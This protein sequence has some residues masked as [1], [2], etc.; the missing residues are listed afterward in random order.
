MKIYVIDNFD[1]ISPLL[2]A[3][4]ADVA[5]FSD[6]IQ[7]F[8]A[9]EQQQPA[10]IFL[11]YALREQQTAEYVSLLIQVCPTASIVIVAAEELDDDNILKL[12]LAGAKGYQV[13][14]DLK[15]YMTRIILAM[16]KG[17][18]WVSRRLVSLLLNWIRRQA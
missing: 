2:L 1:Q 11:N 6:E 8:N 18:A 7:A 17:E 4:Q 16:T 14:Q 9:V 5:F 12:L 13:Q 10:L 3:D 15:L